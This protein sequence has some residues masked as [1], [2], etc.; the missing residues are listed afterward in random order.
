MNDPRIFKTLSIDGGGIKGIYS[1]QILAHLEAEFDCHIA[2][3]F[4]LL[5]GTSTGGLIALALSL[6]IP[7]SDVVSFYR[8]HKDIIFPQIGCVRAWWDQ[9]VGSGKYDNTALRRSL[10]DVFGDKRLG[11]SESLLCIPSYTLDG[12][13][14][15]IFKFDHEE[16]DLKRHN[17]T[18]YVDVALATSAAPTYFPI[19]KIEEHEGHRFIDGGVYANN[20]SPIVLTEA[21]THFVGP[22]KDFDYLKILS[23]ASVETN[24]IGLSHSR[25]RLSARHWRKDLLKPFSVG[26]SHIAHFM[27][28]QFTKHEMLPCDYHRIRSPHLSPEEK[29]HIG[30]DKADDRA[31]KVLLSKANDI[32]H[33]Q[34][35]EPAVRVFFDH[36]KLYKTN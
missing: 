36:K 16:G 24:D 12:N 9:Y 35:A 22:E 34:R 6:R 15:W 11:D 29:K 3:Y 14:P 28:T 23:I 19:V 21:F 30:M 10:K 7:A 33:L 26:Q 17:N 13:R 1:A 25:K 27:L 18:K 32:G 5:C 2:D 8:E 4:D 20:P 31:V